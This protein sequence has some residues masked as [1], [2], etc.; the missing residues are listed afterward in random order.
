MHGS[1]P[2]VPSFPRLAA[3]LCAL[4]LF[5]ACASPPVDPEGTLNRVEGGVMRVGITNNPPWT[6]LSDE[7]AG[8]EID[9]VERLA[10]DLGATVEW[11]E[12]SEEEIFGLLEKRDVDLVVGGITA[13]NPF[14]AVATFT[15]EYHGKHVMAVP[16]GENGWLVT[17]E[18]FLVEQGDIASLLEKHDS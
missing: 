8:V 12:G 3:L 9:L 11:V 15:T 7:P 13:E 1:L 10:E 18:K 17:V 2:G 16:F 6:I 14:S 4:A 5:G